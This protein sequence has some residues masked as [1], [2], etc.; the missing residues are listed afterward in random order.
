MQH[1]I[2]P[3]SFKI[4]SLLIFGITLLCEG[5]QDDLLQ[6]VNLA[7]N[8]YENTLVNQTPSVIVDTFWVERYLNKCTF[9]CYFRKNPEYN[10][11]PSRFKAIVAHRSGGT[12]MMGH[13]INLDTSATYYVDIH[14]KCFE[15]YTY[16]FAIKDID[17]ADTLGITSPITL[18]LN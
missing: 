13:R 11:H 5:C 18:K 14:P 1:S 3:T 2:T 10:I 8:I 16:R 6:D 15:T 9:H 12:T 4:L 7:P 17:G